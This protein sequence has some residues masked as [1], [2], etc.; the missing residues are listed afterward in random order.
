MAHALEGSDDAHLPTLRCVVML[1][2]CRHSSQLS[3]P[4]TGHHPA[5][6]DGLCSLPVQGPDPAEQQLPGC[7]IEGTGTVRG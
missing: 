6:H 7:V 5:W 3:T 2:I 4:G 1:M